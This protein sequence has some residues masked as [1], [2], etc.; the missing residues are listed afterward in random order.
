M[1]GLLAC[2]PEIL[3]WRRWPRGRRLTRNSLLGSCALLDFAV[4]EFRAAC[5]EKSSSPPPCPTPTA[6]P[7]RPSGGVH[8]DRHLGALSEDARPRVPLRVR[9][10][11]AWH[12][13]SC[14]ARKR[15]ASRPGA[16]R[17]RLAASTRAIS[18]AFTSASTTTTPPTR[19]ETR[20]FC[21]DI[22]RQLER[23]GPDRGALG[24]AVLRP[25]QA[26][27]PAR[28]LHQG[29]VPELPFEGP[30]RRLLRGV[31]HDLQPHRSDRALL[32]GVGRHADAQ[33]L[34]A[35]LLQALARATAAASS[36]SGRS[37]ASTCRRRRATRS[38]SGSIRACND[39]DISRDA[40]YFG[41]E[42]P[43]APGKY[44]YVWLDAPIGYLGSFREPVRHAWAWTSTALGAARGRDRDGALHRQGHPLL[45]R[46][47]LAGDAA[48]SPATARPPTS[49]PTA[50]SPWTGRRCPSRAAP[51]SP[52]RAT[53]TRASTRSG[54]A[55]T[56]R[57]SSG[58]TM[59]DID[60]NLE[61]FVA[62]VNS[63]LVGKFVNIASRAAGF[64]RKRFGGRLIEP[65]A[66][67]GRR[68]GAAGPAAVRCARTRSPRPTSGASTARPCAR[69][70]GSPTW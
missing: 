36:S 66:A 4:F 53:C 5:A 64:I 50:F 33:G 32:R 17:A 43:G 25:G 40:P 62:R 20:K 65:R 10:R 58:P 34:R 59:E 19:P 11:H 29:R 27:V 35:P 23:A 13:R 37:P 44:F 63:D 30:V 45:P 15:R 54:C 16:D 39:W 21:E 69:S 7:P 41:F 3:A 1:D 46:A 52:P 47:V 14:C 6:H 48:S 56:M 31:R 26:D 57:P 2:R 22:Y 8:P 60:L 49:T 9:R 67:R 12:R 55:T 42:I 28:P 68:R 51:S 70:C 61:D 38:A 18:P 24:G